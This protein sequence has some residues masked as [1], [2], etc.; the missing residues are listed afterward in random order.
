MTWR[1][2]RDR[3]TAKRQAWLERLER[4]PARRDGLSAGIVGF[5][6]MEL[7]WTR[8]V[9]GGDEEITEAGRAKLE[10]WRAERARP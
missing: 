2:P 10:A 5:E 4:G 8:W 6:C 1:A 9:D 3:W 7:G